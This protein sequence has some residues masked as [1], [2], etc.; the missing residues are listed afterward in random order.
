[1][2]ELCKY[3]SLDATFSTSKDGE[4]DIVKDIPRSRLGIWSKTHPGN[5]CLKGF[6]SEKEA[7]DKLN[8][9]FFCDASRKKDCKFFE[10]KKEKP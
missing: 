6:E 10:P 9:F 5:V 3:E 2:K 7:Y 8:G 1:M 4:F